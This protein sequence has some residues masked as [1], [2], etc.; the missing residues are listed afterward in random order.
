[1][2]QPKTP[3]VCISAVAT[4]VP[5]GKISQGQAAIQAALACGNTPKQA[6]LVGH[7]FKRAGISYRSASIY[8]SNVPGLPPSTFFHYYDADKPH[9]PSTA[10]RMSRYQKDSDLLALEATQSVLQEAKASP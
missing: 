1:M 3:Q 8:D 4:A 5:K 7:L 10:E 9:G 2:P 6:A